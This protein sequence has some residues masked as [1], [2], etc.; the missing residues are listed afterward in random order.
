M[1]IEATSLEEREDLKKRVELQTK[2]QEAIRRSAPDSEIRRIQQQ[3]EELN[4]KLEA[5]AHRTKRN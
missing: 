5:Y 3:I 1:T 2:L 4:R